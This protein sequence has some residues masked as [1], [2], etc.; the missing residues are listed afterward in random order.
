MNALIGFL[1]VIV[2][3][4]AVLV[5]FLLVQVSKWREA[6]DCALDFIPQAA[7]DEVNERIAKNVSRICKGHFA[8]PKEYLDYEREQ[9]DEM[10]EEFLNAEVP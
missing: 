4:L 6:C 9:H 1:I 5:I 3:V 2:I 10:V 7:F 8:V